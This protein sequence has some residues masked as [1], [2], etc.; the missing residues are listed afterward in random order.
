MRYGIFSDVHSNLPALEA[1]FLAYNKES[2]DEYLC[3]GD[4]VGYAA[5]PNECIELVKKQAM[6]TVAGNHDWAAIDLFSTDYFNSV[7]K[8]AIIWT[9]NNLEPAGRYFLGSLNLVYKNEDLTLVHGTL[10]N[11]G[12]FDYMEDTLT[13]LETFRLLDTPVCFVGHTHVPGVFIKDAAGN[14]FYSDSVHL[15]MKEGN[16]YVVNVGSVGQPRD[17]NPQAAYCVYDTKTKEIFIK[18]VSYDINLTRREIIKVRLPLFLS[19]RL[20]LGR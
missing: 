3:A 19:E 7:A 16:Q 6:V 1:V 13:A 14:L 11:P 15:H 8:E 2:V 5:N 12:N 4:V 20:L 9:R 10:S 17:G 18:R